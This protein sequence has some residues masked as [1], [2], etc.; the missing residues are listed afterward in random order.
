MI[1]FPYQDILISNMF[2][3][4]DCYSCIVHIGSI[5]TPSRL[6]A[7]SPCMSG[8]LW[9][10]LQ[11]HLQDLLWEGLHHHPWNQVWNNLWEGLQPDLCKAVQPDLQGRSSQGVLNY[12]RKSLCQCSTDNL[13]N[14]IQGELRFYSE[15]GIILHKE[16]VKC[17]KRVLSINYA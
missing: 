10:C 16:V 8:H 14:R 13:H 1:L 17:I 7:K 5:Y 6:W 3:F 4:S 11:A 2:Y 15:T 9:H 12:L